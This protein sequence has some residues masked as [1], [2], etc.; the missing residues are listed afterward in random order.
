MAQEDKTVTEAVKRGKY[1]LVFLTE[2][3]L[4]GDNTLIPALKCLN[5]EG[6]LLLIAVDEAHCVVQY[7]ESGSFRKHYRELGTLRDA[8]PSV[9]MM[10]LSAV[11]TADMWARIEKSLKMDTDAVR[12]IGSVYRCAVL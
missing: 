1:R 7:P 8:L 9:P 10:A 6:K 4:F 2:Q 3:L 5:A 12:T 11:P